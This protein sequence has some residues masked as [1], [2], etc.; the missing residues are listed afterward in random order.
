[1]LHATLPR[2]C[3]LAVALALGL[4]GIASAADLTIKVPCAGPNTTPPTS[5]ASGLR[6]AINRANANA[7]G[8]TTI[9]LDSG[10]AYVFNNFDNSDA[11][12]PN[13]LPVVAS[14]ITI[15]GDTSGREPA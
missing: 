6:T 8:K 13:A 9:K 14:T 1:M 10:C 5:G 3:G 4:A 11:D 2:A 7:P 12:G 15:V